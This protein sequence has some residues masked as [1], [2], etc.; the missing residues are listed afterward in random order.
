MKK[1]WVGQTLALAAGIHLLVRIVRADRAE[2][3]RQNGKGGHAAGA[4]QD[5]GRRA[6]FLRRL[7][8]THAAQRP[9]VGRIFV[10]RDI[11]EMTPWGKAQYEQTKPSWGQ[12]AVVDSTDPGQS[13]DRQ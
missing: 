2:N 1:Y 11:P 13:D 3:R 12:R 4:S 7:G 6:G 8:G 5:G 9:Q 10:Y